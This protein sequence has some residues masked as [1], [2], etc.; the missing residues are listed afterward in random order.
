K[1]HSVRTGVGYGE[2]NFRRARFSRATITFAPPPLSRG[3]IFFAPAERAENCAALPRPVWSAPSGS[4]PVAEE[5]RDHRGCPSCFIVF[6]SPR[7]SPH[8]QA[9]RSPIP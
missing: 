2:L 6:S 8:R 1:R 5:E 3:R 7:R 9:Q 4:G